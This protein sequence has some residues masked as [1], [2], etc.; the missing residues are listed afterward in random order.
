MPVSWQ[1]KFKRLTQPSV[2][3]E[4]SGDKD[5]SAQ[6]AEGDVAFGP[7][8]PT[9]TELDLQEG[10]DSIATSLINNGNVT[11]ESVQWAEADDTDQF[12]QAIIRALD[13]GILPDDESI[14]FIVWDE[15][16]RRGEF[17][18]WL[19]GFQQKVVATHL[20]QSFHDVPRDHPYYGMIEDVVERGW[21]QGRQAGQVMVFDVDQ[22]LTHEQL[23]QA[24]VVLDKI[25]TQPSPEK[26]NDSAPT[27]LTVDHEDG[28]TLTL[29]R[30]IQASD[31]PDF[32]MVD[33]AYQAF[34][35]AAVRAPWFESRFQQHPDDMLSQG[36]LPHHA[37]SKDMALLALFYHAQ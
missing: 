36:F 18:F 2:S 13:L 8:I 23:A 5:G 3:S 27:D 12:Q 6:L 25:R 17:A 14:D 7:L 37:V 33:K 19:M 35:L 29:E 28:A 30:D 20:L 10:A 11:P 34:V 31:I 26:S 16:I 32:K 4:M 22:P 21:M 24:L 15:P 9:L 1:Q